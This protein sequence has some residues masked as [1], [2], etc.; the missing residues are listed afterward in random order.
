MARILVIEDNA[1][2][3][4]LMT[5]LLEAFGHSVEVARNGELGV[6][7]IDQSGFDLIV[8]DVHLPRMDGYQVVREVKSRVR[9][10]DVP[11]IAVTA[12]AMVGD[13]ERLLQSGFDG[14]VAKPIEPQ[15]F[16]RRIES[17][18]RV[19]T[20]TISEIHRAPDDG[21]RQ[22]QEPMMQNCLAHLLVVDDR[23]ENREL[24]RALLRPHGFEVT[25]C[26]GAQEALAMA[27]R[28]RFDLIVSDLR[29]PVH[30]GL[31]LLEAMKRDT[32]L[33]RVPFVVITAS[34]WTEAER[35]RARQLGAIDFL[36]RPMEPD[37][38]VIRLTGHIAQRVEH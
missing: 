31:D 26:S 13:Q 12:L 19:S 33:A 35:Q 34:T 7:A 2:N 38:L 20:D 11:V 6:E 29:M 4:E 25:T 17:Y 32:V 18:L 36:Q 3:L 21:T 10:A 30:D 22:A 8:C 9:C 15:S 24:L 5:Y 28:N 14:Y 23:A 1:D 37:D 16:V 27:A